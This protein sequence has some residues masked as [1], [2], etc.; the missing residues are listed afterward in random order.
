MT[1]PTLSQSPAAGLSASATVRMYRHG[2]GDC[3]L[4]TFRDGDHPP[5][6]ALIDCGVIAGTPES[7]ERMK[8]VAE[9]IA[10]E[11]GGDLH[12]VA[13]SHEHWDHVSGFVEAGEVFDRMR[14]H[15]LWL[16]WTEDPRDELA[17]QLSE[18]MRK[19][20]QALRLALDRG[21]GAPWAQGLSHLLELYG[22]AAGETAAGRSREALDA[23]RA[24]ARQGKAPV[25]Y[26]RPGDGPLPLPHPAGTA[27]E[28]AVRAYVL[29]PPR[30]ERALRCIRPGRGETYPEKLSA[31]SRTAFRM[32]LQPA[33]ASVKDEEARSLLFP[34]D[35]RVW[36]R[37]DRAP[38]YDFFRDFYGF[39]GDEESTDNGAWRRI[40]EEWLS[41]ASE[42]ALQLDSCTNNTSLV[43]AFEL[44]P[45][46]KVL[47][48]VADAQIGNWLS[49]RTLPPWPGQG[50]DGKVTVADLLART[51]LYKV[52]HHGSHNATVRGTGGDRWGLER[53]E[54]PELVALLPVDAEMARRKGWS[55]MP[56]EPLLDR[57]HQR[58]GGRVLRSDAPFPAPPAGSPDGS[59]EAFRER[60]RETALYY[61]V[62]VEG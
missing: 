31:G 34:F 50:P 48:F 2:L 54:S 21:K 5:F 12:L 57:L 30:D 11:T 33:A 37:K 46:R 62:T 10:R 6:H 26:L 22:P 27:G 51:A 9:D 49:W 43:L 20:R 47:L 4:L 60:V 39:E 16:G 58:A 53:M 28:T 32:A 18:E 24:F 44:L 59:W 13:V 3:F 42:L 29:G 38:R 7:P 23:V 19:D 35:E 56:F 1:E 15:N 52:G 41:T 36:V 17:R 14:V 55:K 61:E 40:D 8:Q 25:R 45:S